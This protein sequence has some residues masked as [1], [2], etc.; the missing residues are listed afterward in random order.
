MSRLLFAGAGLVLL[1]LLAAGSALSQALQPGGPTDFGAVPVGNSQQ[2]TLSYSAGVTTTIS[3][4]AARTEGIAGK[5]FTIS[6]QNCTGTLNPPMSC[7]ITLTFAPTQVGLRRGYLAIADGSGAVVNHVYLRGTGTGAQLAYGPNPATVLNSAASLSP[8]AFTAGAV[9]ADAAGDLFF[10]DIANGRVLERTAAGSFVQLG[11]VRVNGQSTLALDGAGNVYVS[12]PATASVYVI[13]PGAA[14]AVLS[15][16]TVALVTPTGLAADGVGYLYIADAGTQKIVRVS[17]DGSGATPLSF[18]GLTT[19]L[20]SPRGLAVDASNTLYIA[21]S[22]NDR[23]V[24]AGLFTGTA[25]VASISGV[26]LGNPVAVAV[27]GAGTLT[28]ADAGNGRFVV[29]PPAAPVLGQQPQAYALPL[30]GATASAPAGIA[31]LGDGGLILAD[32]TAGL[33]VDPRSNVALNFPTPTRVGTIDTTDGLLPITIENIG[34][35]S[36]TLTLPSSGTNPNINGQAFLDSAGGNTCPVLNAFSTNANRVLPLG[37]ACQYS[38]EFAPTNTG[39][40]TSTFS[41]TAVDTAGSG[42]TV[43]PAISLSGTGTSTLASF[44]VVASPSTTGVNIP[45]GFT[46]T[47]LNAQGQPATDYLGTVTLSS[48]GPAGFLSGSTFTF[49]SADAGVRTFPAAAGVLFNHPGVF[50]FSAT[51][52]QITGISNAISVLNAPAITLT[53]SVN[54]VYVGASVNLTSTVSITGGTPTGSVTFYDGTASL[55]TAPLTNGTAALT[56]SFATT[57]GH[58][59]TAVYSG[60]ANFATVTS[61][62]VVESV[63]DFVLSIALNTSAI[64]SVSPGDTATYLF[65]LTPAGASQFAQPVTLSVSGLPASVV[66]KLSQTTF[67]AGTNAT[68][69]QLSVTPP[70]AAAMAR[71]GGGFAKCAGHLGAVAFALFAVPLAL[72]RRRKLLPLALLLVVGTFCAGLTGCSVANGGGYYLDS[73]ATYTVTITATSGN[74]SHSAVVTLN[75]Q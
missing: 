8:A 57:G 5:D 28:I 23:I 68:G 39:T 12:A 59:L 34:T 10:T 13:A 65:N 74:L 47:A 38:I 25:T 44:M 46:V 6:Q 75:V 42:V 9:V 55:G 72:W 15:T 43:M 14:P 50:Q 66:Y 62:P 35:L 52:N 53:T 4:V 24:E 29:V 71:P 40:N 61:A 51:D 11:S 69:V 37:Y 64:A 33:I 73:P 67:A 41:L 7:S 49:T 2:I 17:L 18:T 22:G 27:N 26:T 58:A 54:P 30:S 3:S 16:G 70:L 32:T 63:S 48:G 36:L 56:T 20:S 1:M 21:D 31:Q 45:V 19:P 60:D